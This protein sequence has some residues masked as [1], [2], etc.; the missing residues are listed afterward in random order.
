LASGEP[1][2]LERQIGRYCEQLELNLA[3]VRSAAASEDARA[4]AR[5]AHRLVGDGRMIDARD[6]VAA[7]ENLEHEARGLDGARQALLVA[8]LVAAV[9]DVRQR[10]IPREIA[11]RRAAVD[12]RE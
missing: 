8:A 1:D 2:G 7:A 4:T 6:L 9:S 10:L 11:L 3:A 5:S 12:P